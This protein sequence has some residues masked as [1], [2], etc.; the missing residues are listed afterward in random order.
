MMR[1]RSKSLS[2]FELFHSL[3]IMF[4]LD[5]FSIKI[6]NRLTD[7]MLEKYTESKRLYAD[8]TQVILKE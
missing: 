6:K 3:C 7:V 4:V 8:A 2:H 5:C 1:L